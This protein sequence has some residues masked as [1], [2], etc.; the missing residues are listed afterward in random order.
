MWFGD[1]GVI[2]NLGGVG[3]P[4]TS[5]A[6]AQLSVWIFSSS[7]GL[8]SA[9]LFPPPAAMS[10][11]TAASQENIRRTAGTSKRDRQSE[12]SLCTTKV[13][14]WN[15]LFCLTFT[16]VTILCVSAY[17]ATFIQGQLLVLPEFVSSWRHQLKG[18][19][20]VHQGVPHKLEE[21]RH[22]VP[23]QEGAWRAKCENGGTVLLP[24]FTTLSTSVAAGRKFY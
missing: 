12:P 8:R 1:E 15:C 9:G 11:C 5:T 3:D 21:H 22:L 18:L 19:P 2:S 6:S 4:G 24:V 7:S 10:A 16:F 14:G 23:G 17:Q 20:A 13:N